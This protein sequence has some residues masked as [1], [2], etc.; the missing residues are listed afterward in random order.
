MKWALVR[1][2]DGARH[3]RENISLAGAGRDIPIDQIL[4]SIRD[5]V[6]T[7][8]AEWRVTFSNRAA[9]KFAGCSAAELLGRSTW[10][11]FPR[12]P[13]NAFFNELHRAAAERTK[14]H[15]EGYCSCIDRWL[16][17]DIH[18]TADGLLV[19]TRDV[20]AAKRRA[21]DGDERLRL[22][23][24]SA[25][26]GVWE[27]D[28]KTRQVRASPE[29][30]AVH[31]VP[32]GTFAGDKTATIFSLVHP[33]DRE[34]VHN[35]F[36]EAVQNQRS[37]SNEFR[38]VWPD[39]SIRFLSSRGTLLCDD[40]GQPVSVLGISVDITA[41]KRD[42]RQVEQK[43]E[44]MHVLSGLAEA[45]NR[46]EE[47]SEIYLTAL[48]GLK[49]AV[50]S[51][52]ASVLIFDSDGVMR[53]KAWTGLSD[54]YRE[55]ASGHTPWK[56]GEAGALPITVPDVCGEPSLAGLL[57][58]LQAEGI[59]SVAFVPLLGRGGVIGKFM[60]YYDQP[61]EFLAEELQV[62]QTIA[63]QV[64]FAAERKAAEA[65]LQESE[66]RFRAT[67]FQAAVGITQADISGRFQLVNDRFCQILGYSREEMVQMNF[68]D[69]THPD[70][71]DTCGSKVRDLAAGKIPAYTTEKRFLHKNGSCVWARV[72]VSVVRDLNGESQYF[73]GVVEETTERILAERALRE[74]EER[75][76]LALSAA[77]LRVW[78]C[79]LEQEVVTVSPP[80][81]DGRDARRGFAEYLAVIHPDDRERMER[82]G[83]AC[84]NG[85]QDMDAECRTVLPD[86][87]V[88]WEH[89]S[90]RAVRDDSGNTTRLIGVSLDITERKQTETALRESEELF[91]NLADTAPVMMWIAGPDKLCTFFNKTWLSFTGRT[92]EQEMGN[93]WAEG[94]HPD[95][96][97]ACYFAYC[98]AFDARRNFYI[99]YRLRR[100]D[101]E[102]RWVICSGVPRF[103][104]DGTFAGYIGSDVD[105]TELKRT[106]AEAVERD[107][108]ESLR[109]LTNGIAHDFNNLLGS[110]L[111]IAE[112]G[113]LEIAAGLPGG[114]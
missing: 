14:G 36:F 98:E 99:E 41:Q 8:D 95:D 88:Q 91:R 64:A 87:R 100:A 40:M 101:G 79:D 43:L 63:A 109:V 71:R 90:A 30:E 108:L 12:G 84:V 46:A 16:D 53:F 83:R 103:A 10:D 67:F 34:K 72:N 37:F 45:V 114:R 97:A 31:G 39:G 112:M 5:A 38:I 60:L 89:T 29:L 44:Q 105:I 55:A 106:Q 96:A 78:D 19:I 81:V 57:P 11:I 2:E 94:I 3:L 61:H 68:L 66:E 69:I 48:H 62:A 9:A 52:R 50:G 24:S 51:D 76:T 73:I 110:V 104:S 56:H 102:Y 7:L 92:V 74:S 86:G 1:D 27:C 6:V 23:L 21:R 18:P 75:L 54:Q 32:P 47:P 80:Y 42:A 70:D 26:A 4:E 33:E 49:R 13:G 111:A 82:L 65:A 17:S 107:K 35:A 28:I 58:V 15:F 59:R 85:E 113:E 77:R 20:T 22:A 25:K 93:G